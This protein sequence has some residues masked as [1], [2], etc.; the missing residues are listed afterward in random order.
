MVTKIS[1][2]INVV[3]IVTI[4]TIDFQKVYARGGGSGASRRYTP[5]THRG[6]AETNGSNGDMVTALI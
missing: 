6:F 1:N 3:T 4:V 5:L 2:E